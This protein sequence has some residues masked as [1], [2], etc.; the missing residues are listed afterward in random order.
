MVY[1]EPKRAWMIQAM[2]YANVDKAY[3]IHT[4]YWSP[5]AYLRDEAKKE[6]N[7]WWTFGA[8]EVWVYEY[9]R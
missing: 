1:D 5:A 3:F 7:A 6:A 2:D 9:V 8:D 4:S